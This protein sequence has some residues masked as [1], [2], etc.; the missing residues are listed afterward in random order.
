M[1]NDLFEN[2]LLQAYP[3]PDRVGCPG[4]DKLRDLAQH[5]QSIDDPL[6][7][8]VQHC[9]PCF[10]E[11]R[12]FRDGRRA[13]ERRALTVRLSVGTMALAAALAL[14]IYLF[15]GRVTHTPLSAAGESLELA[16]LDFSDELAAR[17]TAAPAPATPT[18]KASARILILRLPAGSESGDYDIEIRSAADISNK[19]KELP[20]AQLQQSAVNPQ[21]RCLLNPPLLPP[22][23]YIAAWRLHGTQLW[24]YGAFSIAS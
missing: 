9:S 1:A 2:L 11:F 18:I 3:N 23:S 21:L 5:P 10:Q 19:V 22:G 7:L 16:Q 24:H 12:E 20:G 4:A 14:T 6:S 15:H 13:A 8:H 17:G